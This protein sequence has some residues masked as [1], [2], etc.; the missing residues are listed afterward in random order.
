MSWVQNYDPLGSPLLSTMAAAVPLLVLLGLLAWHRVPA[1][2]AALLGLAAA[3]VSAVLIVGMPYGIALRAAAFGGA[4]GLFPIGWIIVNVLFLFRLAEGR[5]RLAALQDGIT[6][7][8][9]D[10]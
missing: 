3:L 8:T 6:A 4:Y 1:H 9:S 2:V 5:G 7:I 10:R